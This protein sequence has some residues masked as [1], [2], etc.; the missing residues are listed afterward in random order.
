MIF[1]DKGTEDAMLST[2]KNIKNKYPEMPESYY[3][4]ETLRCRYPEWSDTKL[5]Y[6][7]GDCPDIESLA[8]K[9]ENYE[10]SEGL[11]S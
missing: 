4:E 3:L 10:K 5:I 7:I 9:I 8:K 2:Y 1:T 11:F 6:F